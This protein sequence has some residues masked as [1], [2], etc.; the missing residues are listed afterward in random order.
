MSCDY[1]NNTIISKNFRPPR[2]STLTSKKYGS[3]FGLGQY[4]KFI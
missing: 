3:N 1:C 2:F 4:N